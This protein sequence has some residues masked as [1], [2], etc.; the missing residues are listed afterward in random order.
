MLDPDWV[1]GHADDF[2]VFHI[3]FGFDACSPSLLHELVAVL[4]EFGKPLVLTVH[5]LRNPHHDTPAAHDEHLDIL[6]PAADALITLTAGAAAEIERRWG[7][8]ARVVPHPHVLDLADLLSREVGASGAPRTS[9][10][11]AQSRP[12]LVGLHLKSMRPCM[13]GAPVVAALMDTVEEMGNATLRIDVHRDV[14]EADGDRH[15]AVLVE[16][17]HAAHAR[18]AQL[19]VH[20]FFSDAQ[21]WAYLADLDVSVLPY[22]YGTHSGW[23]EACR[24]LG[25]AVAAPTCGY[26]ADQGPVF[27]FGLNEAGLDA[28]SLTR[29]VWA[30][31]AAGRPAP[32]CAVTRTAQRERIAALH[33]QIYRDVLARA[34]RAGKR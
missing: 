23:L 27:S 29:A 11:A 5:D 22:R 14:A 16:A 19:H 32:L 7:R 12:F 13:S 31:R 1:R 17:L 8:V 30:A 25:T 15:D 4:A 9:A 3:H 26:Y 6:V 24:D 28:V 34:E 18:G 2:D 20:D 33:E 10:A 21:L